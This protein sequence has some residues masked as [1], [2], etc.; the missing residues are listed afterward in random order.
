LKIRNEVE[1]LKDEGFTPW[2]QRKRVHK[3]WTVFGLYDGFQ[4]DEPEKLEK[5]LRRGDPV[6]SPS[7]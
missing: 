5:N 1:Q 4:R 6:G 7:K 3:G 2:Y